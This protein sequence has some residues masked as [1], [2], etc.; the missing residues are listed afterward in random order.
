MVPT[1]RPTPHG[2]R[3]NFAPSGPLRDFYTPPR[4]PESETWTASADRRPRPIRTAKK[5]HP[6]I[7]CGNSRARAYVVEACGFTSQVSD[8][9]RVLPL[10]L[11]GPESIGVQLWRVARRTASTELETSVGVRA[12]DASQAPADRDQHHGTWRPISARPGSRGHPQVS[13]AYQMRAGGALGARV[14]RWRPRGGRAGGYGQISPAPVRAPLIAR[15]RAA[16]RAC[17]S[18][19]RYHSTISCLA[20]SGLFYLEASTQLPHSA[21]RQR[22]C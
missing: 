10:R 11:S 1:T 14:E 6:Y 21:A 18:S 4:P 12:A 2:M 19:L 13:H 5:T 8:R 3:P 15:R 22:S 9:R 16:N 20:R 7:R 17:T